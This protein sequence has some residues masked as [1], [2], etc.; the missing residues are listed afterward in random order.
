MLGS[1]LFALPAMILAHHGPAELSLHSS[2]ISSSSSSSS[3]TPRSPAQGSQDV[4]HQYAHHGT[5]DPKA[6]A[7]DVCAF[8]AGDHAHQHD[9]RIFMSWSLLLITLLTLFILQSAQKKSWRQ[10]AKLVNVSSHVSHD[11]KAADGTLIFLTTGFLRSTS[12]LRLALGRPEGHIRMTEMS[13]M[14]YQ[15]KKN[16][17]CQEVTMVLRK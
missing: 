12:V 9:Q 2:P 14:R 3:S 1:S 11:I 10:E 6:F 7:L 4:Q 8:G 5:V 15:L 17:W 16:A 13:F